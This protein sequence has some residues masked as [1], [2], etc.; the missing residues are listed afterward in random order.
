MDMKETEVVHIALENLK[1]TA[2]IDGVWNTGAGTNPDGTLTFNIENEILIFNIEV[3]KELRNYQM[4]RLEQ[5]AI[6]Y[7]PFMIVA[8]RI[9]PN[10]KE[11][12][13]Q[14]SIAYLEANGNIF[15]NQNR[16]HYFIDVNKPV[17]LEKEKGNRAFT[18]TGTKV[19]FH[20]LVNDELLNFPHREIAEITRVAHG[21]IAYILNGL[22]ENGF[23]IRLN[24]NKLQL[25]NKKE[26]LEKWMVTY[27]ET[28]QPAI[29]IGRFKF[30]D[31]KDFINWKNIPLNEGKTWW[32]GEPAGDLLTNYLRPGE[33]TLY[34]TENRNEIIK[35]YRLIPDNQGNVIVYRKFW[36]EKYDTNRN[37]VPAILTY[38]DLMNTGN[39]RCQ[40]VAQIIWKKY[41]ANM[42]Y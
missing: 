32:G 12:L 24:K 10:I 19:I 14:Q 4:I 5:W 41:L 20:L 17:H 23:L 2:R 1:K 36:N 35:N 13:R 6:L 25:N 42:F 33:L 18:K 31:R 37:V 40:E 16:F 9:F 15:F 28:L 30:A 8:E 38:A 7:K 11:Q 34:T 39:G 21:N 26:L 29:K 3:K 22:K 27:K